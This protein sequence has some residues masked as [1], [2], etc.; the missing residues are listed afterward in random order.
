M[1][2]KLF[3]LQ[4]NR[5]WHR[6]DVSPFSYKLLPCGPLLTSV[7]LILHCCVR[8]S[9]SPMLLPMLS[10]VCQKAT[11]QGS[12]S[13]TQ[14]SEVEPSSCWTWSVWDQIFMKD[15]RCIV[16][17]SRNDPTVLV[18]RKPQALRMQSQPLLGGRQLQSRLSDSKSLFASFLKE[19]LVP[20]PLQLPE[21]CVCFNNKLN[22]S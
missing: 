1:R 6:V 7:L 17:I 19:V 12:L 20:F 3:F 18:P 5:T 2:W 22:L 21:S 9:H 10:G 13:I 8:L 16:M 11:Y 14:C 4:G 15:L